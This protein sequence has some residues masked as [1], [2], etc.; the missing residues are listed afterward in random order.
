GDAARKRGKFKDAIIYYQRC[1]DM[2]ELNNYALFGLADC[3]KALRK[4]NQAIKIWEQYL[5]HDSGNITVLTR[6]ADAYRKVKD[7]KGSKEVYLKVLEIEKDNPYALIGLGHLH[8]DFKEFREALHYWEKMVEVR[9]DSI[10]IRV[11]TSLGNCHRKLKSHDSG[12]KYFQQALAI[13]PNNFYALFGLAD[14]FRGL[15]RDEESLA[16]WQKILKLDPYNKVIL[17][18]AGDSYRAMGDFDNA[19]EYYQKALNIEFDAYAILGLALIN[20][21]K[22]NFENAIESLQGLLKNDRKN[23]RLY[24]EIAEC[25]LVLGKK[26]KA[27]EI[28]EEFQKMGIRNIYVTNLLSRIKTG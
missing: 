5:V 26:I 28:L 9:S 14:C 7:F 11:L 10:D 16:C 15:N 8:Y 22:G 6:V 27:V 25:Y 20:K 13:E 18:R 3:Y 17:T 2:Y 12:L 23:H 19:E 1:L 24:T 21:E 4:Y